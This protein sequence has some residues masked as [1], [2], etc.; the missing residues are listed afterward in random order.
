MVI[1]NYNFPDWTRRR[2]SF[3]TIT[4]CLSG[5]PVVGVLLQASTHHVYK[6]CTHALQYK[7]PQ[8]YDEVHSVFCVCVGFALC[9]HPS[10]CPSVVPHHPCPVSAWWWPAP[11]RWA[12]NPGSAWPCP[13]P[14]WRWNHS[15]LDPKHGTPRG[16]LH[17]KN[18]HN[19][20]PN[21]T[22]CL[23]CQRSFQSFEYIRIITG[24]DKRWHCDGSIFFLNEVKRVSFPSCRCWFVVFSSVWD[25]A[26]SVMWDVNESFTSALLCHLFS[27]PCFVCVLKFGDSSQ[28]MKLSVHLSSLL[29]TAGSSLIAWLSLVC[30][31]C[32]C[33]C[34]LKRFPCSLHF[35]L[36]IH[37][38]DAVT[39][40]HPSRHQSTSF[41]FHCT[42]AIILTSVRVI[43]LSNRLFH[44][45]SVWSLPCCVMSV[46]V[47]M[48]ALP[49]T[50]QIV[51]IMTVVS[52]EQR[53]K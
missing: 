49:V 43:L 21:I 11:P 19:I 16:F 1:G 31:V 32:V 22:V 53:Q 44:I 12:C 37:I 47:P 7:Q 20:S 50:L 35:F 33:V 51:W 40:S 45:L 5:S 8:I 10:V 42:S 9:M 29:P 27:C 41:D 14:V 17:G 25:E 18:T 30:P 6:H 15:H 34:V 46:T 13:A 26:D 28:Q 52:Q 38:W 48:S 3:T 24:L 23:H 39:D 36:F 4:T 2:D